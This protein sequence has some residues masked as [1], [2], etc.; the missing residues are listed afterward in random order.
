MSLGEE[1]AG[2]GFEGQ[3][4]CLWALSA[5]FLEQLAQAYLPELARPHHRSNPPH[6]SGLKQQRLSSWS[7]YKLINGQ[8]SPWTDRAD[9][10][11]VAMGKEH[12]IWASALAGFP[13][14][15]EFYHF[16]PDLIGQRESHG[17]AQLQGA[18]GL[19]ASCGEREAQGMGSGH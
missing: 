4:F 1:V 14:E 13:L 19:Q 12:S 5:P 10:L 9:P 16:C 7:C 15:R 6:L 3:P 2:P 11:P 8:L 18:R 17:Q